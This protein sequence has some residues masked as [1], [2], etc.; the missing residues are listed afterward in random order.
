MKLYKLERT[1][2]TDYDEYDSVII[3]AKS[4]KDAR[5]QSP[6][7][8]E[9]TDGKWMKVLRGQDYED[10]HHGWVDPN[11][12]DT[13]DVT[14]LGHTKLKRGVVLASFNAG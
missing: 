11:K 7:G 13:L 3:A 10:R 6:A 9:I 5:K 14:F 12:V 1:D 4:P 8:Y 2:K